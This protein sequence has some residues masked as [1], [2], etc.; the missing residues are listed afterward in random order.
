MYQIVLIASF[1]QQIE[2]L[3]LLRILLF[4]LPSITTKNARP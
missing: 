2:D 3:P 1:T 4:V